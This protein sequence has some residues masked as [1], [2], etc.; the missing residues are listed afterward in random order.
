M[1]WVCLGVCVV[2]VGVSA[3]A[4]YVSVTTGRAA[5]AVF[6]QVAV[7]QERMGLFSSCASRLETDVHEMRERLLDRV[8]PRATAKPAASGPAP[9]GERVFPVKRDWRVPL[10]ERDV[11]ASPGSI[12]AE[13]PDGV[14]PAPV[15]A[16]SDPVMAAYDRAEAGDAALASRG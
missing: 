8:A 2:A 10:S 4:L 11:T 14:V 7:L 3:W 1:I 12:D 5:L 13:H 16:S 6:Q 9:S 15:F